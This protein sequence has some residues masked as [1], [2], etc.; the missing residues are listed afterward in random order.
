M[1]SSNK[2]NADETRQVIPVNTVQAAKLLTLPNNVAG[3]GALV[4]VLKAHRDK[5][6]QFFNAVAIRN[7]FNT[8]SRP[9]ALVASGQV[10]ALNEVIEL[11]DSLTVGGTDGR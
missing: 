8:E 7:V 2:R 1:T 10:K 6:N 3:F 4:E 9:T 11:L 5:T